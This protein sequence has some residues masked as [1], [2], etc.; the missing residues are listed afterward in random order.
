MCSLKN[1]SRQYLFITQWFNEKVYSG[2]EGDEKGYSG[3]EGHGYLDLF[4][5]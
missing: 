5:M 1:I 4:Q 3:S 2:S